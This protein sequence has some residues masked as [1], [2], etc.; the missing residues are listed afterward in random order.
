M[1]RDASPSRTAEATRSST[2][3]LPAKV[4]VGFMRSHWIKL[5]RGGLGSQS[6][7][8]ELPAC[9]RGEEVAVAGADVR[10]RRYARTAAQHH[11]PAHELAVVL[12][13]RTVLGLPSHLIAARPRLARCPQM[14]GLNVPRKH[15]KRDWSPHSS[16]KHPHCKLS[17]RFSHGRTAYLIQLQAGCAHVGSEASPL[18]FPDPNAFGTKLP[19]AGQTFRSCSLRDG[20][21]RCG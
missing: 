13:Q 20:A 14:L 10:R 15:T 2:R 11:L 18:L 7:P 5:Q 19:N 4:A 6:N 21:K 8:G 9:L 12:S 1:G 17:N 3:I 16:E